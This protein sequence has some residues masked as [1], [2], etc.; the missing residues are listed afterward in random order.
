MET[1]GVYTRGLRGRERDR[2][3]GWGYPPTA[4]ASTRTDCEGFWLYDIY[5]GSLEDGDSVVIATFWTANTPRDDEGLSV[6]GSDAPVLFSEVTPGGLIPTA[7]WVVKNLDCATYATTNG[8]KVALE[9]ASTGKYL[10]AVGGWGGNANA[11]ATSAHSYERF[12]MIF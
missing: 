10:T 4:D 12:E 7:V 11:T 9:N 1:G 3:P 6:E 8:T 2:P 5:D